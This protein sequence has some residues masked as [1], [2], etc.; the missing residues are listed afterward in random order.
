[1]FKVIT[2]ENSATSSISGLTIFLVGPILDAP[3]EH[4]EKILKRLEEL[5]VSKE[6]NLTVLTARVK[7]VE[8]SDESLREHH[9]ENHEWIKSQFESALQQGVVLFYFPKRISTT[10]EKYALVA[11][12]Q[13]SIALFSHRIQASRV[14]LF[15][16]LGYEFDQYLEKDLQ[17]C[18]LVARN[19]TIAKAC[20]IAVTLARRRAHGYTRFVIDHYGNG[21]HNL[22]ASD[23]EVSVKQ[24]STVED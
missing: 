14:V 21:I 19:H 13:L 24:S 9:L 6:M 5:A 22:Q 2:P 3:K 17:K 10:V 4:Y 12:R 20:D 7:D 23:D 1:M 11:E 15:A 18:T 16:E 8:H